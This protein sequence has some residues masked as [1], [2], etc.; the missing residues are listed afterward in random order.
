MRCFRQ[1]S[2]SFWPKIIRGNINTS[3]IPGRL[4]SGSNFAF[5][6]F[7]YIRLLEFQ[8]QASLLSYADLKT[9]GPAKEKMVKESSR[10]K[11]LELE[12]EAEALIEEAIS[13]KAHRPRYNI[14]FRDDKQYFFVAFT[15]ERF[16]RIFLPPQPIRKEARLPLGSRASK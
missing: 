3:N 11:W 10:V 2:R 16:P 8:F 9:L 4:R 14:V 5:S 6:R 13:I 1:S 7:Q 12:S 15:K